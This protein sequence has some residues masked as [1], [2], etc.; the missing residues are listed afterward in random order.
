MFNRSTILC[1]SILVVMM[2]FIFGGCAAPPAHRG[3]GDDFT[4]NLI[5]LVPPREADRREHYIVHADGALRAQRGPAAQPG[6]TPPL[7]RRLSDPHLEEVQFLAR[8]ALA[9][10]EDAPAV[11]N[12]LLEEPPTQGA[13]V[14][15]WMRTERDVTALRV[16]QPDGLGPPHVALLIERLRKLAFLDP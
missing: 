3:P 8:N 9:A 14:I 11:G 1:L 16:E 2:S 15:L 6:R 4:L 5:V 12:P 10:V 7:A 13:A